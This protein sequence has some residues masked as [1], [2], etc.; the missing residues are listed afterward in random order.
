MNYK[1]VDILWLGHAGFEI[2]TK[3][4]VI[5][6]DPYVKT[7]EKADIIL[8]THGHYDHF[9]P[10]RIREILKD[11]TV[12]ILP[13]SMKGKTDPDWNVIFTRPGKVINRGVVIETVP[14]YNIGK[15]YHKKDSCVGYVVDI[16]GTR[17]YHSGDTDLIPEM[18]DIK[19][20]IA[21]L[22]VGGTYT[23]DAEEAAKAVELIQP[24][25]AIPMHYGTIIGSVS[26]AQRFK[27]LV[28]NADVKILEE[29]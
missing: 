21:L 12:V 20:D 27:S 4:K 15:P 16:N 10:E 14:A 8:I 9:S 7:D 22:P 29:I 3:D 1:G 18:K 25:I 5:Y 13:E 2:L 17:I 28:K 19:C 11:S 6:I 26:D 24:K 23:M